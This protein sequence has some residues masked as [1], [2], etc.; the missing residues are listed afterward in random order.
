MPENRALK[1]MKKNL[2][3]IKETDNSKIIFED[4]NMSLSKI[5]NYTEIKQ[6]WKKSSNNSINLLALPLF[7]EPSTQQQLFKHT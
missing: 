4:F 2:T 1:Y 7:A 5:H 3:E 6:G